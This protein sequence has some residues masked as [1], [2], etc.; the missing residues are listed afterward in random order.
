[1]SDLPREV[2]TDILSRLPVRSLLRFRSTSKSW[3]TLIESHHFNSLHLRRSLTWNATNTSLILRLDSDLYETNFPALDPPVP[4]NHPLMC[5]SNKITLLG[6]VNGLLCIS[7]VADDIAFWNPSLRK[8]RILPYLPVP[9]RADP[10]TTLFAARVHGFGFDTFTGDYKLVRISYFVDLHDRS[11]DSQV[12]LYTLRANAWRTLPSMPYALCCART[13]GVFVGNSLHWVVTRKLEPDQPDL[14]IAFD[15]RREIFREVPLPEVEGGG[16]EIDVAL[17]G[18]CLCMTVNFQNARTDVW[19]M[20]VYGL[21]D[22]W[23]KL[24]TLVESR[25]MRSLKCVRPLGYSRDGNKVLLEHDRR[26]LCWYDLGNK[27]VTLVRI[28]GL[29]NLNEA[30]I[31]SGTL[32]PPSLPRENCRKTRNLGCE[33]PRKTRYCL[34]FVFLDFFISERNFYLTGPSYGSLIPLFCVFV[35]VLCYKIFCIFWL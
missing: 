15:L 31:C 30:M 32:V 29:P 13:M 12:K 33:R 16:F 28:P 10:D 2:I 8:H 3:R 9:R 23:C 19:V 21:R 25:E 35:Y 11:F 18:G 24:F 6:S 20:G 26:K 5:Y 17:L 14:I 1:M 7:N 4:L 27:Q 34:N 22:S